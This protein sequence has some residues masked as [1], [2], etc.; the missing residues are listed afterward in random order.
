MQLAG[1]S[2]FYNS[3]VGRTCAIIKN[4][5][6]LQ[7]PGTW[8]ELRHVQEI[9]IEDEDTN[10]RIFPEQIA[11]LRHLQVL[12]VRWSCLKMLSAHL[13]KLPVT[14]AYLPHNK[15]QSAAGTH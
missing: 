2:V 3:E 4:T 10:F 14:H 8:R 9:Y 13:E 1:L 7:L 15:L 6:L 11:Q 5:S 12:S